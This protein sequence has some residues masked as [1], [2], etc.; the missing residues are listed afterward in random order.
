MNGTS[1]AEY[2]E[3]SPTM[4][5]VESIMASMLQQGLLNG[6]LTH[7]NPRFAVAGSKAGG[8]P[9]KVAFPTVWQTAS[10]RSTNEVPGWVKD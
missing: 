4:A 2:E 1:A 7:T 8:G 6:F 10:R 5:E 9:L 3:E